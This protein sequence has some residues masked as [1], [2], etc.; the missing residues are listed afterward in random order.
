M[1]D[2]LDYIAMVA[3]CGSMLLGGVAV[4]ALAFGAFALSMMEPGSLM[5]AASWLVG[6]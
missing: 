2:L 5:A 4:L 6:G 1:R 3:F